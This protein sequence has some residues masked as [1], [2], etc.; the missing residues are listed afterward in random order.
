MA[1]LEAFTTMKA[2]AAGLIR[3]AQTDS[4][5]CV[6]VLIDPVGGASMLAAS[7]QG[8]MFYKTLHSAIDHFERGE[9]SGVVRHENPNAGVN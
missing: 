4:F 9:K 3:Q 2:A 7:H 6:V 8:S 1:N 5:F